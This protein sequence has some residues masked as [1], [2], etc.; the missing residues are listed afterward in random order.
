MAFFILEKREKVIYQTRL[1]EIKVVR[2][3]E[4]KK[5]ND[6]YW[7]ITKLY[8]QEV[9]KI[10]FIT[11]VFYSKY[12]IFF[13]FNHIKNYSVYAKNALEVKNINKEYRKK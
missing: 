9:N 3:F 8:K 1:Q 6:G 13:L 2:I 12:S 11:E 7:D 4:Y 10:L 5:K